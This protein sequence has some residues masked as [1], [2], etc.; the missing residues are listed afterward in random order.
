MRLRDLF[1]LAVVAVL[2]FAVPKCA[3]GAPV[4][5][6]L[7]DDLYTLA[8]KMSGLP[9]QQEL[10]Q[11]HVVS[12]AEL[13]K[14]ACVTP[15]PHIKGVQTGNDIYLHE[16][17]DMN[18]VFHVSIL[19][20]ELVHHLQWYNGETA[21]GCRAEAEREMQ[22]YQLQSAMLHFTTG[23]GLRPPTMPRCEE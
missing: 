15:C 18:R 4:P 22:A 14:I 19:F 10:P 23:E 16:M 11:I 8:S 1:A 21:L 12:Q 7:A 9:R 5:P 6:G 2:F 13:E 17:L 20:H 3:F